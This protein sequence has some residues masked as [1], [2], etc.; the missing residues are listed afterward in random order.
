[1]DVLFRENRRTVDSPRVVE[2]KNELDALKQELKRTRG[3][4]KRLVLNDEIRSV[5][6]EL[7]R[8]MD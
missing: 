1:M 2:L 7:A 6:A 5:A 4:W 3:G 8:H